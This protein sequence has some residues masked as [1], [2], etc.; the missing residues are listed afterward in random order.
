VGADLREAA[1]GQIRVAVEQCPRDGQLEDAVPEKLEPLVRI[2]PIGRPRRMRER[3]IEQRIRQA[4]D[5]RPE[6]GGIP[7]LGAVVT[8]A[9]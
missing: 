3:R 6:S 9:T 5:Q 8:G 2:G 7:D 1:L 4:G